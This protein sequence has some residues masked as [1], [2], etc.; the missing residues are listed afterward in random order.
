MLDQRPGTPE[1]DGHTDSICRRSVSLSRF[2]APSRHVDSPD[3]DDSTDG[4]RELQGLSVAKTNMVSAPV[5]CVDDRIGFAGEFIV[6]AF[7]DETAYD[8]GRVAAVK[9]VIPK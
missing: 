8:G 6:Q 2:S 9:G 4:R 3:L 1:I 7:C 5:N